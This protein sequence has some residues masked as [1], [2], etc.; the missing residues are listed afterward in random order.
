MEY[1]PFNKWNH[2]AAHI[3]TD[4]EGNYEIYNFQIIDGRIF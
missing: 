2:G 1:K 4:R 3:K